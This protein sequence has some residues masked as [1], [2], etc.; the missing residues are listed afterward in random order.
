MA[1]RVGQERSLLFDGR[2]LVTDPTGRI[3]ADAPSGNAIILMASV[4][5]EKCSDGPARKYFLNSRRPEHYDRGAVSLNE[6][7]PVHRAALEGVDDNPDE[8]A[9]GGE[10]GVDE[11]AVAEETD[12]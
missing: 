12:E 2:S 8:T 6:S 3:V 7:T 11:G 5:L 1:N 4:D 10:A 9:S